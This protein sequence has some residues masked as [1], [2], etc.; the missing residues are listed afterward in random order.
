MAL[1]QFL[2]F[3]FTSFLFFLAFTLLFCTDKKAFC[4]RAHVQIAFPAILVAILYSLFNLLLNVSL[5][6]GLLF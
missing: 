1:L 6:R 2:G 4:R 5:P 3:Y